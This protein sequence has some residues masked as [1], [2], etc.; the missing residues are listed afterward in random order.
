M[1]TERPVGPEG[2]K[3]SR[4]SRALAGFPAASYPFPTGLDH[5]ASQTATSP[6]CGSRNLR[7][8]L[9]HICLGELLVGVLVHH[10]HFLFLLWIER[11]GYPLAGFQAPMMSKIEE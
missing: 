9:G 10:F 7:L 1:V 11:T 4:P 6:G 8:R 2:P 5:P 3:E